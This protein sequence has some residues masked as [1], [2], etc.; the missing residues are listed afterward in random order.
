MAEARSRAWYFPPPPAAPPFSPLPASP[1]RL[2]TDRPGRRASASFRA[3]ALAACLLLIPLV[4]C[5]RTA[6]ASGASDADAAPTIKSVIHLDS[7][8]VNLTGGNAFLR[9]GI[10]VGLTAAPKADASQ[11]PP[12]ALIR[13]TILGVLTTCSADQLLTDAGKE[14]LKQ[15][16]LTALQ[17]R[18]PDLN[19][20]A[21]YFTDFLVQQ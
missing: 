12:I 17:K 9:V 21:V 6:Q 10:D 18:D 5:H 19:V 4:G 15:R 11:G 20:G 8:L 3:A 7:F 14:Q 13:D 2:A 16:L 1:P